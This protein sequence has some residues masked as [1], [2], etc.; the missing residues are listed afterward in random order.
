MKVSSRR[1]KERAGNN[2]TN[3]KGVCQLTSRAAGRVESF[4]AENCF[5]SSNLNDGIDRRVDDRHAGGEVLFTEFAHNLGARGMLVA[6][7]TRKSALR[8]QRI[9]EIFGETGIGVGEV[10]PIARHRHAGNLPVAGRGVLATRGLDCKSPLAGQARRLEPE[11]K[12][13]ACCFAGV[14]QAQGYE[15]RNVQR[16]DLSDMPK[17]VGAF[18]AVGRGIRRSPY[19]E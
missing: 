15:V 5:V 8:N 18:I 2:S 4:E 10:S 17:G 1:T 9:G 19:A 16:H 11:W 6:E 3:T 14:G 13:S 7:Q 12:I